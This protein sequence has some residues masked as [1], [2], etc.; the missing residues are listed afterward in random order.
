MKGERPTPQTDA[1]RGAS[2]P[3]PLVALLLQQI[4]ES[5]PMTFAEF[6]GACLYH[7]EHGYYTRRN[8]AEAADYVTSVDVHP[9]FG[10]LLA[11]QFAEMWR[12][13]GAPREFWLAE[14]GAGTGRLTAQILDF[15][16]RELPEF[17]GA[18]RYCAVEFSA[19]R[20]AAHKQALA[21]H[22]AARRAES[23]VELPRAIPL[24]AI[25][26]NELLDALPVHRV[27]R[28]RG[29]LR[30]IYVG[31]DGDGRLVESAGP[32][33]TPALAEYFRGQGIELAEGQVAEAG[34]GAA[35]WIEDAGRRLGRGFVLTIDYGYAAREM[36]DA[37]RVGGTL[38]GYERH[39]TTEDWLRAPGEQDLT[40]H[41][42]FTAL[43]MAGRR[44]GLEPAGFVSQSQFL[45]ALT[46]ANRLADF[47][48]AGAS[49]S[50]RYRTR[51]AF[52]T[53]VHPDGM[54]EA[55][56]VFVQEKGIRGARLSG[57]LPI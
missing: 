11:R 39:R 53:L 18:V 14:G 35:R 32:L 51:L 44:T 45:L 55:F 37:V 3:T 57:F 48:D 15:A 36:Y 16:A 31:A 20:R 6:M 40:A 34:L 56:R 46:G 26:S 19:A 33:S 22:I 21:A 8:A 25:F 54:G 17:Y 27:V 50:E 12:E 42:N 41:V 4:S 52:Q 5:G 28:V 47:E 30:E 29:E 10:R 24:G 9:I 43:E 13:M 23:L 38:L 49:E 1:A 7:P 2:E